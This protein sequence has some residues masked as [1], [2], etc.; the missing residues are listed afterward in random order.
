[1]KDIPLFPKIV[2][3][4]LLYAFY[5][6]VATI[7][8][9]F[10]FPAILKLLDK[11]IPDERDPVFFKT[12]IIIFVL[13]FVISVIFRKYL[14]IS[15]ERHKNIIQNVDTE[16]WRI[17]SWKK[18]QDKADIPHRDDQLQNDSDMKIYFG[19]EIKEWN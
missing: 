17:Q 1:M 15:L 16:K 5:V 13:V 12:Q 7:A 3:N 19:K 9:S 2:L 14:Y 18:N 4:I 6:W 8:F 10:V 11:V